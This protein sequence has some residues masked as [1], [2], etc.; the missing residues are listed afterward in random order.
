MPLRMLLWVGGALL[1]AACNPALAGRD[2][3]IVNPRPDAPWSRAA[4]GSL[5]GARS[6]G[7][8]VAISSYKG[9]G[10]QPLAT[11]STD[12]QKMIDFLIKDAGFDV[13]FVLTDDEV[14]KPRIERLML[15]EVRP[16]VDENDRLLVYWSGHGDQLVAGTRKFGFLPLINSK[17]DQFSGMV[18]MDDISRWDN[19]INARQSLFVLDVCLSGLAGSG[20]KS[21]RDNRLRQLSRPAHHAFTAGTGGEEAISGDRWTGSLFTDSLIRGARGEASNPE[22]IVSLWSL[23]EYVQHRVAVEVAATRWQSTLTPRVVSLT[24]DSGAFFFTPKPAVR[25]DGAVPDMRNNPATPQINKGFETGRI[26]V[27]RPPPDRPPLLTDEPQ[28][29][30]YA[31]LPDQASVAPASPTDRNSCV[32]AAQRKFRSTVEQLLPTLGSKLV[33]NT[34]TTQY[35]KRGMPKAFAL[36]IDWKNSTPDERA[37]AGFG[38]ATPVS[39]G[40]ARTIDSTAL[41]NCALISPDGN[42]SRCCT[43]VDRGDGV[44]LSF[45]PDWPSACDKASAN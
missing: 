6:I 32:E 29:N 27:A 16:I 35:F 19:Y 12:A 7:V 39:G 22:G 1:I 5:S 13:V 18:S 42:R 15:D 20:V 8:V 45:P 30:T 9:G 4:G 38:F 37:G 34:D 25:R 23:L 40:S 10:Y 33:Y 44:K 2:E 3:K 36:C 31:K 28:T 21:A 43:I 41:G 11:A 26:E 24:A 17:R 14:T